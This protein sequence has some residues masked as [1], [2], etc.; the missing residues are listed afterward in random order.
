MTIVVKITNTN[1][2]GEHRVRVHRCVMTVEGVKAEDGVCI[3][4]GE[5]AEF[6][7]W[8]QDVKLAVEEEYE[9]TGYINQEPKEPSDEDPIV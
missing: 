7:I 1:T 9:V 4:N 2:G 6:T 3:G 8:G 5:S